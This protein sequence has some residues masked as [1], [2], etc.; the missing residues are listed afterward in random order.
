MGGSAICQE[1]NGQSDTSVGDGLTQRGPWRCDG[2][3]SEQM[4]Q[5]AS[6]RLTEQ[7]QTRMNCRPHQTLGF[8]APVLCNT[9][10]KVVF[11]NRGHHHVHITC[12]SYH[13]IPKRRTCQTSRHVCRASATWAYHRCCTSASRQL[14]VQSLDSLLLLPYSE[15]SNA[16][17]SC[18]L[19]ALCR[20]RSRVWPT[21]SPNVCPSLFFS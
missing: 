16:S 19:S 6:P 20:H 10:L 14:D 3:M 8:T 7:S 12:R 15:K 13:V 5:H 4:S 11:L 2:T 1:R 21:S 9:G 17:L 18:C